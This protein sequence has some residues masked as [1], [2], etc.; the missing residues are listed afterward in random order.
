MWLGLKMNSDALMQAIQMPKENSRVRPFNPART[1]FT[2]WAVS[3]P[4]PE[5]EMPTS[6]IRLNKKCWQFSGAVLK[7]LRVA[8][9]MFCGITKPE[10]CNP[11][12]LL[13]VNP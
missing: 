11:K 9:Y 2:Y 12:Q 1:S 10:T 3:L 5:K 4:L 8:R 13:N 6:W 7:T